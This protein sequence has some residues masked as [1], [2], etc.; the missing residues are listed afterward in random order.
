MQPS[1]INFFISDILINQVQPSPFFL[2][3]TAITILKYF[4]IYEFKSGRIPVIFWDLDRKFLYSKKM[5]RF[6][7]DIGIK[8]YFLAILVASLWNQKA[9]RWISGRYGWREKIKT[10][11]DPQDRVIWFHCA[12]LGE[13]EQGR[14]IIEHVRKKFPDRK[15]LLSFF[16]PS[17]F[18]KRRNYEAADLVVY[19]PLDTKRNVREFL[20]HLPLEK[21]FFIKYE[22]WFH[23]LRELHL[24]KIQVY[25]ASGNFRS[26]QLFFK[27]YG[28]WYRSMLGFFDHIFVQNTTSEELLSGLEMKNVSVAGDTRF[29]RVLKIAGEPK[30]IHKLKDFK[31]D[32]PLIV[33][34]STWERDEEILLKA[35]EHFGEKLRW[36]IAPHEPSI[37]N[38]DRLSLL[39]G[40]TLKLTRLIEAGNTDAQVV[41]VD[42]IG[43]LSSL[44]N[45]ATIAY[46]GG[47]FGK[48]IH[49]ILEAVAH[50]KA[51]MFGPNYHSFQ[52]A[53]D[54]ISAG[55]AY[56]VNQ[57]Q[58]VVMHTEVMVNNLEI[59]KEASQIAEN[60]V[61]KNSGATDRIV[62]FVFLKNE[63]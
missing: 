13:F 51:V 24:K 20:K 25:L 56:V 62:D 16:S 53:H 61:I 9:Y 40:S 8:L 44:Y 27:S 26:N 3:C 10:A 49:N 54:L 37:K 34:G 31:G 63:A 48:G 45:Y 46:I 60:Y 52:E 50:G 14:P 33:A 15:I 19:L 43:H 39:F 55:I 21:V 29:D 59:Q 7:Y 35:Y 36:V 38:I 18:E 5:M 47:G 17:G 42:T 28:R 4:L 58:D 30:D 41:L 22:F 32:K 6:F 12:S 11:F 23:M 57:H 1:T 2:Y